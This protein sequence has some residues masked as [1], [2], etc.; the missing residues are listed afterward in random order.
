MSSETLVPPTKPRRVVFLIGLVAMG[1][2][3]AAVF[4]VADRA[5][6]KQ[7]VADWSDQQ[8][9]A[10][11]RL[12]QPEH[13]SAEDELVL[14]GNVSAFTSGTMFARASGYVTSWDTDIGAHVIKGQTL[15]VV[16]APD[17]DQQLEEAKAQ[18]IQLDAAVRQAQANADLGKVTD[19]RTSKLVVQGWS[20]QA[21]GDTDHLTA[22]SREAALAV[23]KANVVA[24]QAAVNRLTELAAFE[25]VKAPF[26]GVVTARNVDVGDLVNAGGTTGRALFRSPT[27]TACAFT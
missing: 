3:A 13:S 27:F 5:K 16:S 23:A 18:I 22:S 17:L 7:E 12:V 11:V 20:S 19:Q 2:V 1:A 10:T 9:V 25:Q 26:G 8:A 14:P 4:G 24:Q 21:Q 6:S 15:A